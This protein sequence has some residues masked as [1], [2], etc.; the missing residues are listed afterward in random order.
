MK[1]GKACGINSIPSELWWLTSIQEILSPVL[2]QGIWDCSGAWG[3]ECFWH[4]F[5]WALTTQL[6]SWIC[7]AYTNLLCKALIIPWTIHM[8]NRELY[9]NLPRADSITR[10]R[11]VHFAGH[12]VW[13]IADRY[14]PVA[15]L[16]FWQGSGPMLRG[17]GSR[18]TFLKTVLQDLGGQTSAAEVLDALSTGI[19]EEAESIISYRPVNINWHVYNSFIDI[20]SF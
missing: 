15:D 5:H 13:C 12:A 1:T 19:K 8:I 7:G 17:Q 10:H 2:N 20:Y 3:M 11:R 4:C 6:T 14:Q 16:V 18:R 9:G